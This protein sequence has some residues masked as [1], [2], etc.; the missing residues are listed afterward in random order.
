M[1]E[2]APM[3]HRRLRSSWSRVEGQE[4]GWVRSIVG[5]GE[6]TLARAHYG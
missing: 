6:P 1:T 5:Q 2:I 4:I 3:A